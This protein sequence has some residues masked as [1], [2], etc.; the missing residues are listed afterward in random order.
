MKKLIFVSILL[1]VSMGIVY[2]QSVNVTSPA[3]GVTWNKDTAHNITWTSPG[4]QSGDVKINIF[5]D[6]IIQA[7][8]VLQLTGP[9]NG[10]KNWTVPNNFEDG[11]YY[12]R[13]KTD[14]AE[15]GCL[16]DS[17]AFTIGTDVSSTTTLQPMQAEAY[18]IKTP[19]LEIKIIP[20][21]SPEAEINKKMLMEFKVDNIGKANSKATK[22]R[23]FMG[24]SN[25]DT[26]DVPVLEP[27]RFFY[28]TKEVIPEGVG[29]YMWSADVDKANNMGDTNRANN[30]AKYKQN[31]KG[32][33]LVVAFDA[34]IRSI[35]TTTATVKGYV[36]NIG[37]VKSTP[38][39]LNIYM[40][41]KG[42]ERFSIPALNP[43]QVFVVSRGEKYFI[44]QTITVNMFIDVEGPLPYRTVKEENEK[45]NFVQDSLKVV[46]KSPYWATNYVCSNGNTGSLESIW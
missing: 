34:N 20:V 21:T 15:T 7:N 35:I 1:L 27:G 17:G 32:S 8:F 18:F 22:M 41:K 37:S 38:C 42:S 43:G 33:D 45:N 12:I 23:V 2:S 11:T 28:K 36:K 24:Q 25:T 5:K 44:A 16:G 30:F 10:S 39:K 46:L 4:C 19:D 31:I 29:Y 14:P 3:A 9:N 26:W 13:V 40:E 6:S